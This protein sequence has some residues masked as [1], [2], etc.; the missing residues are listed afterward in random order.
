MVR[1]LFCLVLGVFLFSAC[2]K[3]ALQS[4]YEQS[5]VAWQDFKKLSDNTYSYTVTTSSWSGSGTSTIVKVTNGV[6]TGRDYTAF[7]VDSQS[8]QR[9]TY[10]FWTENPANLNSHKSGAVSMNLDAVYEKAASIWL[11]ADTK[12]NTVYFETNNHGMI[13]NCGY[14]SRDCADDCFT[15]ITITEILPKMGLD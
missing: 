9:T 4:R 8:G 12:Q 5:H 1:C 10:E 3:D 11:K 15:G 13:S 14:T 6:V 7:R 2:K